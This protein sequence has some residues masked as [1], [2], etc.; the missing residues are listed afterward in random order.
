MSSLLAAWALFDRKLPSCNANAINALF[1]RQHI[2]RTN[3]WVA[4]GHSFCLSSRFFPVRW[5]HKMWG[6]GIRGNPNA[7]LSFLFFFVCS[8][9]FVPHTEG[10][11]E[12]VGTWR[13]SHAVIHWSLCLHFLIQQ[14]GF[15]YRLGHCVCRKGGGLLQVLAVQIGAELFLFK[16]EFWPGK[17]KQKTKLLFF[18]WKEK[19]ASR[20]MWAN[21]LT[22]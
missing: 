18:F 21:T 4:W 15:S 11:W 1:T 14:A 13:V 6:R 17:T 7:H 8:H 22:F 12:G 16:V 3:T 5:R 19:P 2:T 10:N 20:D 9:S